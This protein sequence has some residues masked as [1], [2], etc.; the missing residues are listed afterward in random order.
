MASIGLNVYAFCV[1]DGAAKQVDLHNVIQGKD[2]LTIVKEFIAENLVNYVDNHTKESIYKF[3]DWEI[4]QV[5]DKQGNPYFKYLYGRLK[6]GNYGVETEIVDRRTGGTTYT[7]NTQEAQ[8]MPFD[9][10][11]ILPEGSAMQ[12]VFIMQT[13]GI[14][15]IKSQLGSG[16]MHY[17]K[18]LDST[19]IGNF[20]PLYP[21]TYV[22]KFLE[23]GELKKLRLIRNFIPKDDADKFGIIP[24]DRRRASKQELVISSSGGFTEKIKDSIRACLYGKKVYSEIVELDGFDYDDLKVELQRGNRNK[25]VSLKNIEKL[26]ITE[27]I[28]NEI[29]IEGGHPL[30]ESIIPVMRETGLEYL[31]Q[32]ISLEKIEDIQ[33]KV[34]EQ[35]EKGDEE[36]ADS[37]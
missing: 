6:T 2:I 21:R 25:V 37:N 36:G 9:F 23:E 17:I 19:L 32:M 26:V 16:L 33:E 27:D 7:Q 35:Y 24:G 28:T 4:V 18:K 22:E 8:V 34:L 20:G 29:D 12:T 3:V 10:M 30:K 5:T 1:F 14:Y 13:Q 15:G 31:E 11:V